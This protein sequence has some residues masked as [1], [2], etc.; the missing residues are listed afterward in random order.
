MAC[1]CSLPK[2][3]NNKYLQKIQLCGQ[4][5]AQQVPDMPKQINYQ[6]DADELATIRHAIAHDKRA[7][8]R[9]RATA[10]HLLHQGQKPQAVAEMLVVTL[11]SVYKWHHRW[12]MQGLDGLADLPRSG[13]PPKA[14]AAYWQRLAEVI[15]TTPHELGYSF[16]V[17][18]AKRLAA[19]MAQET[20]IHLSVSRLRTVL[21]R[22]SEVARTPKHDRNS[23]Q[24]PRARSTAETREET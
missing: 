12:R 16:S 19:H 4:E 7:E 2:E 11:S 8:V 24:D 5:I 6:L 18:T 13:A 1:L 15:V 23:S 9:H 14:D 17:W 10:I 21:R 22:G 3:I 20:G